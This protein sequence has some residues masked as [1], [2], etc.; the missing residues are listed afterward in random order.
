MKKSSRIR[1]QHD[2]EK[3]LKWNLAMNIT[4]GLQWLNGDS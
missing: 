3:L 2:N 1:N 4:V